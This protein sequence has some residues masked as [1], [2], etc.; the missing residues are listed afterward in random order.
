MTTAVV[1]AIC[2]PC[3]TCLVQLGMFVQ[4]IRDDRARIKAIEDEKLPERV[5][6]IETVMTGSLE[7]QK[8]PNGK[9]HSA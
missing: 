5:F 4:I 7:R 9:A 2:I 8:S 3:V 1:V 6:A